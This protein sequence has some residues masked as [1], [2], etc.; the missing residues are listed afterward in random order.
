MGLAP[1]GLGGLLVPVQPLAVTIGR[2]PQAHAQR[3][4]ALLRGGLEPVHMQQRSE[5][6][7][8][9]PGSAASR[10]RGPSHA[11]ALA[12]GLRK[13]AAT[14]SHSPAARLS[15]A[16]RQPWRGAAGWAGPLRRGHGRCPFL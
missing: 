16:H 8:R 9:R 14:S 7:H 15:W 1:V 13:L 12:P 4:V 5:R 11:A 3:L 6:P 2:G 10:R